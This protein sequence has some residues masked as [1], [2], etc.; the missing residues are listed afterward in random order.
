MSFIIIFGTL[1]FPIAAVQSQNTVSLKITIFQEKQKHFMCNIFDM[2]YTE[3]SNSFPVL[4]G[5]MHLLS[6]TDY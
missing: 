4:W 2:M 3:N 5:Q 6:K 1:S